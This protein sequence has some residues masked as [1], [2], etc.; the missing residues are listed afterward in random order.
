M[1]TVRCKST[2]TSTITSPP[3]RATTALF[4]PFRPC[5]R[6]D[7]R[8]VYLKADS[9]PDNAIELPYSDETIPEGFYPVQVEIGIQDNN[10]VEIKSGVEQGA[11][12][13]TQYMTGSAT[14]WD[15]YGMVY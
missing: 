10:N 7:L 2:A 14:S 5:A 4:C 12:V 6:W 8:T 9:M 1:R 13:F 3:A 15:N 11:E